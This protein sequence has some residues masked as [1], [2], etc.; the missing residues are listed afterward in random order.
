[1][2]V[3]QEAQCSLSNSRIAF[4][5]QKSAICKVEENTSFMKNVLLKLSLHFISLTSCK[6]IIEFEGWEKQ[7]DSDFSKNWLVLEKVL[8]IGSSSQGSSDSRLK[9]VLW[10]RQ[11][12]KF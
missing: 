12:L 7:K 6:E 10:K 8:S 1:M 11:L 5:L 3:I 4:F 9:G 2:N